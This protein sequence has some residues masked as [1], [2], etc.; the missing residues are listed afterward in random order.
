MC[1]EVQLELPGGDLEPGVCL[2][3]LTVLDVCCVDCQFNGLSYFLVGGFNV[4]IT[5]LPINPHGH[6]ATIGSGVV[7]TLLNHLSIRYFGSTTR[8]S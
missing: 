3:V 2:I 5:V 6:F 4:G 7:I 8:S 1:E